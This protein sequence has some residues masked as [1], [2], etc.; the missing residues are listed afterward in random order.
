MNE[1]GQRQSN[2]STFEM[3]QGHNHDHWRRTEDEE[4]ARWGHNPN[5]NDDG[6]RR[7]RIAVTSL[8]VLALLAIA[9]DYFTS[10]RIEQACINFIHWIEV[11]PLQGMLAVIVVYTLATILFVPGAILTVGCGFAFRSAFDSTAKGVAVASVAV[12]IG[13]F[14]G[15]L[16]SFLLGRYLFRDCVLRLA[17]NYPIMR[18]VDRGKSFCGRLCFYLLFRSQLR[19]VSFR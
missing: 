3:Q 18:A 5:R 2:R 17:S 9:V 16:G 15:S 19:N 13:A 12:F 14:V 6:G 7:Q 10:R 11:H 8:L 4:E 1:K